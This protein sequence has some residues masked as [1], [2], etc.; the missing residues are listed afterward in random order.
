MTFFNHFMVAGLYPFHDGRSD[1]L[2]G[3]FCAKEVQGHL[4]HIN[5][6]AIGMNINRIR[7]ILNQTAELLLAFPEI[8]F[9]PLACRN[10]AVGTAISQEGATIVQKRNP[11]R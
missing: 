2:I 9:H 10:V 8:L 11:I 5:K 3:R 4:I 6:H 1:Q 7:C